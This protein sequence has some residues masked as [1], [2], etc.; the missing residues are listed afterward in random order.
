MSSTTTVSN[1]AKD[2]AKDAKEAVK[3]AKT[4]A[5]GSKDVQDDLQALRDDVA[6]LTS[7]IGELLATTGNAAWEKAKASMGGVISD[8]ETKGEEAVEAV[9]DVRDNLVR[10]IDDSLKERPYTTLVLALGIGFLFGA[11]WR[12]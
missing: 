3:D 11:T 2:A 10:A 6:H 12:R 4:A 8:A 5:T 9:R 1:A 7:Q